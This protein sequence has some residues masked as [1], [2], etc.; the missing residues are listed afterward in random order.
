MRKQSCKCSV[1]I[2]KSHTQTDGG[3][4][5]F[6]KLDQEKNFFFSKYKYQRC[7]SLYTAILT[8]SLVFFLSDSV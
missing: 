2:I 6:T 4:T 8:L 1:S 5:V 7:S 3:D